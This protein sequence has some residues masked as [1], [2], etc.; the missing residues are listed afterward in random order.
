MKSLI[1]VC[2]L[3]IVLTSFNQSFS[4]SKL[5]LEA[6]IGT[7][8]T[9]FDYIREFPDL[10]FTTGDNSFINLALMK[11]LKK[12]FSYGLEVAYYRFDVI[13]TYLPLDPIRK[14]GGARNDYWGF[15]PKVQKDF[16]FL[17]KAGIILSS[18]LHLNYNSQQ[19]YQY[20]GGE[21]QGGVR[22]ANGDPRI[23]VKIYGTRYVEKVSFLFKPEI[24]LFYDI[25]DKSRIMITA[26]WGLDLRE[27]SIVIDLDRIEFEGET[28]QNK[29]FFSGNYFSGLL[30]YRYSF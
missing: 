18:T 23:P 16:R 21:L 27:P 7:G 14:V 24:G 2:S 17:P 28:Y 12:N 25:T 11:S 26:R 10:V 19:E 15:G 13:A 1:L 22:L 3:V 4:Q 5:S 8:N 29:Y 9:K 6:R 20:Q 30:G